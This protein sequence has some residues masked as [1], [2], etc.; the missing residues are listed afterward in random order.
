MGVKSHICFSLLPSLPFIFKKLFG[1]ANKMAQVRTPAAKADD[2]S[3][4][5]M[6]QM[7]DGEK[8]LLKVIP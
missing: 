6:T 3:S 8:Q 2:L 4:I 7:M 1:G 5:P